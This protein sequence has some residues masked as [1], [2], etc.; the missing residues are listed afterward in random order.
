[1]AKRSVAVPVLLAVSAVMFAVAPFL[2]NNAPYE[3]TMGLVQKIFYFHVPSAIMTMASA[4]VCGVASSV[5]LRRRSPG[6]DHVAIAAAELAVVFGIIMLLTGPLWARKAWG[7]WWQWEARLT[8]ALLM[9]MLMV[10]YLMLRRF[11]GPGSELLG[12]AVGIFAMVLTP[13]VYFSVNIWRTLHPQTTVVRSLEP[14]M[15]QPFWFCFLA[16]VIIYT[17]LL[18]MRARIERGRLA[19]D[20]AYAALED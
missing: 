6:S 7:V 13:F 18:L 14:G 16:F 17:A 1:M 8:M 15:A 3:S 12:A 4:I 9:W 5:Y 19:I 2:I 11:A 20:E 10:A